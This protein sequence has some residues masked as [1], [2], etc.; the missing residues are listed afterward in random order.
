MMNYC[1]NIYPSPT[2]PAIT[3]FHPQSENQEEL[4]MESSNYKKEGVKEAN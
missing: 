1:K 2:E 4:R 3:M